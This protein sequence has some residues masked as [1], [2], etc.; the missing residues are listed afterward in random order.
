MDNSHSVSLRV[1]V[2]VIVSVI[3]A[4]LVIVE[5]PVTETGYEEINMQITVYIHNIYFR[6]TLIIHQLI[7]LTL[8]LVNISSL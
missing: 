7:S 2:V 8:I 1:E 5:E 4:V 6:F 3:V